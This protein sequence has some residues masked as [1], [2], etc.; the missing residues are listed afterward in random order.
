MIPGHFWFLTSG[1]VEMATKQ[2]RNVFFTV[3]FTEEN[4]V[5]EAGMLLEVDFPEWVTYMV[6]QLEVGAEGGEHFQGYMEFMG[7]H[8]FKQICEIPGLERAHLEPRRGTQ[9]QADQY[10]RKTDTRVDGPWSW[11]SMKEQGIVISVRWKSRQSFLELIYAVGSRSDILLVKEKVDAG[12]PLKRVTDEHFGTMM[13][14]GK[15]IANYK[16]QNTRPR[17]FKSI[18]VLFCGPAG[19]GKSTFA[20]RLATYLGTLYKAPQPKNSG[21]YYDDYD[22]ETVML[23]DEFDGHR[24]KPTDFNELFDRHEVVLPTHG[25]AGH[26]MVSKYIFICSKNAARNWNR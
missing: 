13:R 25:S 20:K 17:D 12:A 3:N 10:C 16:R 22:G 26:Q 19:T 11:G 5:E 9:L 7:K 8:S 18:V 6:Y 23:L 2:Y 4:P 14:I 15:A 1:F 24:M 21:A